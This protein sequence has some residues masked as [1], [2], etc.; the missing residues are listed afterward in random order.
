MRYDAEIRV[1]DMLDLVHVSIRLWSTEGL[2]H[3]K[4]QLVLVQAFSVPGEGVDDPLEWMENAL[5]SMTE[6]LWSRETPVL[7][8]GASGLRANSQD[9]IDGTCDKRQAGRWRVG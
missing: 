7:G 6:Y 3:E 1:F 4:P 9:T 5:C 2:S 8:T